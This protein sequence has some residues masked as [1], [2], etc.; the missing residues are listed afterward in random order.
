MVNALRK[1]VK[2]KPGGIVEV[3][4]P[5]LIAGSI[6]EVI[7]LQDVVPRNNKALVELI[8]AGKGIF[9]SPEDADKFIAE[10]RNSWED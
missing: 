5:D 9:D 10:E 4:S 8:G 2:V 1:K 7:V 6:V 3:R